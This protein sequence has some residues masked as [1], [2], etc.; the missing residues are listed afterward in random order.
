MRIQWI[1]RDC[2][3]CWWVNEHSV[4]DEPSSCPECYSVDIMHEE[5]DLFDEM[6]DDDENPA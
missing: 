1:C 5:D 4:K 2:D 3:C 6:E